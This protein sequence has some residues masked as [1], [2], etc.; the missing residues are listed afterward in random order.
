MVGRTPARNGQ[1]CLRGAQKRNDSGGWWLWAGDGGEWRGEG[2]SKRAGS[3]SSGIIA[4]LTS[5]NAILY[6]GEKFSTPVVAL[7]AILRC[8]LQI[9]FQVFQGLKVQHGL[10]IYSIEVRETDEAV[11]NRDSCDFVYHERFEDYE[12]VWRERLKLADEGADGHTS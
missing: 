3:R 4:M 9:M 5:S 1:R 6:F 7:L 12:G 11:L 2:N 10:P 8:G